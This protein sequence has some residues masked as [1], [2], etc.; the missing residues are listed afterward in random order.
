MIFIQSI[1][2]S[3]L[4]FVIISIMPHL[5]LKGAKPTIETYLYNV[6]GYIILTITLYSL[7][8]T[9]GNTIFVLILPFS[10]FLYFQLKNK[11]SFRYI[12]NK[13]EIKF[14][15]IL[16][17]FFSIIY[18]IQFGLLFEFNSEYIKLPHSDYLFYSNVAKNLNK[19]QIESFH[20]SP[21]AHN[22]P[23]HYFEL[24]L[25]AFLNL[26]GLKSY[27][28]LLLM[29]YPIILT[30]SCFTTFVLLN[31]NTIF[32]IKNLI[33]SV[34]IIFM[35][36]SS[37]PL[38]FDNIP[39]LTG[40][41]NVFNIS[42]ISY[43]KISIILLFFLISLLVYKNHGINYFLIFVSTGIA[44]YSPLILGLI[45]ILFGATLLKIFNK[46]SKISYLSIFYF[47]FLIF[48]FQIFYMFNGYKSNFDIEFNIEFIKTIIN[49]V[50]GTIIRLIAFSIVYI[51]IA[52]YIRKII[53]S[54]IQNN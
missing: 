49:I 48:T 17:I 40:D 32:E 25:N 4:Y 14:I 54:Q 29:V 51:I 3:V 47:T 26:F 44:I 9:K 53:I 24:W 15:S 30:L 31:K 42:V 43:Q 22:I 7:I 38:I 5:K 36:L 21:L 28:T 50:A 11:L 18:V 41:A 19:Y 23:Y 10:C 45:G 27:I 33:I 8:L 20:F 46:K 35:Q 6:V 52:I 1:I 16:L 34:S 13:I 37:L 12:I 2:I 39:F